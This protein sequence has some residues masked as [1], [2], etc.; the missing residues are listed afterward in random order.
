[1]IVC[2]MGPYSIRKD[3]TQYYRVMKGRKRIASFL[4]FSQAELY[5]HSIMEGLK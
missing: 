2:M 4:L 5:L 3:G 1:M